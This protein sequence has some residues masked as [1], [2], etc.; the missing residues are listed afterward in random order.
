MLGFRVKGPGDP[1]PYRFKGS[2]L[3]LRGQKVLFCR[4]WGH[5]QGLV[6]MDLE[7]VP[8]EASTASV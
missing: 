3:Y 6:K 4:V 7:G 8:I 5:R 2:T 1:K